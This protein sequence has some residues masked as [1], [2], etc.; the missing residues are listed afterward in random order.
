M[1]D[2]EDKVQVIQ[3]QPIID[4]LNE[5]EPRSDFKIHKFIREKFI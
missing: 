4:Q 2:V 1:E 3:S 5:N